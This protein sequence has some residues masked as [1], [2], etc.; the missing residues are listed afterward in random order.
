M[1]ITSQNIIV[2]IQHSE[3]QDSSFATQGGWL[4]WYG[5]YSPNKGSLSSCSCRCLWIPPAYEIHQL[6][7]ALTQVS[8]QFSLSSLPPLTRHNP[9]LPHSIPPPSF[10]PSLIPFHSIY[11]TQH[12]FPPNVCSHLQDSFSYTAEMGTICVCRSILSLC[13]TA[14]LRGMVQWTNCGWGSFYY[15]QFL[16]GWADFCFTAHVFCFATKSWHAMSFVINIPTTKLLINVCVSSSIERTLIWRQW[17]SILMKSVSRT[18]VIFI[19]LIWGHGRKSQGSIP[20]TFP[21]ICYNPPVHITSLYS[22]HRNTGNDK[23]Q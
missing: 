14:P 22:V 8:L 20:S 19:C 16:R 2:H 12:S 4:Y 5:V 9:I 15:E 1:V 3:G 21:S 10:T 18:S 11:F 6:G 13:F 23:F 7:K 17:E